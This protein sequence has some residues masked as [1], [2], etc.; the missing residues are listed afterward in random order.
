MR[1]IYA[2]THMRQKDNMGKT[3]SKRSVD[4]TTEA[5]K[6]PDEDVGKLEKIEDLDQKQLN[7]DAS[8]QDN[9][10]TEALQ[11]KGGDE[12]END[13]DLTTEKS[14]GE[15]GAQDGGGDSNTGQCNTS[16][17][18]PASKE[19][20]SAASKDGNKTA[21]EIS[22]LADENNK[23][24]KKE[25]VKKK[26]SFRSI[27]FGKK[28]K[29]KP[30]KSE[31]AA[32]ETAA[33]TNCEA[34]AQPGEGAATEETADDEAA[35]V[36]EAKKL[37]EKPVENGGNSSEKELHGEKTSTSTTPTEEQPTKV[38]SSN[39][40]ATNITNNTTETKNSVENNSTTATENNQTEKQTTTTAIIAAA[41]TFVNPPSVVS[42]GDATEN[43]GTAALSTVDDQ[44]DQVKDK[45]TDL[46]GETSDVAEK[47]KSIPNE[48]SDNN[49]VHQNGTS[50]NGEE[51]ETEIESKSQVEVIFQTDPAALTDD[52]VTLTTATTSSSPKST[53][54]L[55]PDPNTE[56]AKIE[57]GT[58][59]SESMITELTE[60]KIEQT[61][62]ATDSAT[63]VVVD[64]ALKA[65]EPVSTSIVSDT[66][67]IVVANVD[68]GNEEPLEP[69]YRNANQP[70]QSAVGSHYENEGE[71]LSTAVSATSTAQDSPKPPPLPVS[72]PPSQVSVFAFNDN[73]QAE[74]EGICAA[75]PEIVTG[76]GTS[77]PSSAVPCS[78]INR[79]P[80]LQQSSNEEL[81]NKED[82][83][84]EILSSSLETKSATT[85]Q[86]VQNESNTETITAD[87]IEKPE[88]LE[89]AENSIKQ[90]EE[91]SV[92]KLAANE[93]LSTTSLPN[94]TG[95]IARLREHT[96]ENKEAEF[97]KAATAVVDE[98]TEKA[99]EL[100]HQQKDNHPQPEV[101]VSD[102]II[103]TNHD[104]KTENIEISNHS[105]DGIKNNAILLNFV[106]API[107]EVIAQLEPST[108]KCD[109][110]T[111]LAD[112]S[113]LH[114][115]IK[116]TDK[117]LVDTEIRSD[118]VV[119]VNEA[120]N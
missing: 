120:Q 93:E 12:T 82:I 81:L 97:V 99:V 9:A 62:I 67:S 15:S 101:D 6:T 10:E 88:I 48:V 40:N 83:A 63:S 54:F 105:S 56:S 66:V 119:S 102:E 107:Q 77:E 27:S 114:G 5:K 20:D 79:M 100:I 23:K 113:H 96:L 34:A 59:I 42:N 29:Q 1:T 39:E 7:G 51:L 35:G 92:E 13:K 14:G 57:T 74:E 94:S 21:E 71:D 52:L 22:P 55:L 108:I 110:T 111:P 47:I 69:A 72:P 4:I 60:R 80:D 26:W 73:N 11:K 84:I 37:C 38:I 61:A 44:K 118:S 65:I 18:E 45:A 25:K 70:A 28:D 89:V 109:A 90:V 3:Q 68:A 103:A 41:E 85:A 2:L 49:A 17:V 86:S 16:A 30:V 19:D 46:M 8:S 32:T 87:A 58:P 98:I 95:E 76:I 50:A 33:T 112:K 64:A 75:S 78:D 115:C 31:D 24:P 43:N 53:P 104:L 36:S 91:N 116:S 106:D 117:H